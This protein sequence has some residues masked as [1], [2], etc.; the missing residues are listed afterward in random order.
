L[1]FEALEDRALLSTMWTV[2]SLGDAG[3]GVGQ[4]GDLRYVI[5]QADQTLGDNTINFSVTGTIGLNSALPE[6]S[7]NTGLMD[8]EGP[9][10]ANL[11][12]ARNRATWT[13]N[14]RIFTVDSGAD[15]KLVGLMCTGGLADDGN[16]G[17]IY[18]AGTLDVDHC[19]VSGNVAAGNPGGPASPSGNAYGVR[20][21][22]QAI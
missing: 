8:I 1:T 22:P 12:V 4:S 21:T 9:G 6:L 5:T 16:G 18:N 13:P 14:F 11:T 20:F 3:T 10:S 2:D 15:V 17:G 7:N 19:T